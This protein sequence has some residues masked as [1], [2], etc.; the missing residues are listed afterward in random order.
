MYVFGYD[1][2]SLKG[3]YYFFF[4]FVEIIQ[5]LKSLTLRNLAVTGRYSCHLHFSQIS[6]LL[7]IFVLFKLFHIFWNFAII[8]IKNVMAF[9]LHFLRSLSFPFQLPGFLV[10]FKNDFFHVVFDKIF[11]LRIIML[12]VLWERSHGADA[13]MVELREADVLFLNQLWF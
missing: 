12:F 2:K 7:I 9:L 5:I 8:F 10:F 13:L 4:H 3:A 1:R 11:S 6:D